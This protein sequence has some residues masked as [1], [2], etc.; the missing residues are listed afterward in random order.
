MN[1]MKNLLLTVLC[2][3]LSV[4][5]AVH[6]VEDGSVFN[7]LTT[8]IVTPHYAWG[9]ELRQGSIRALFVVA[10]NPTP[11]FKYGMQ[12]GARQVVE[13]AQRGDLD[14]D[15]VTAD[16][17]MATRKDDPQLA[18]FLDESFDSYRYSGTQRDDKEKDLLAKL[19]KPHDLYVLA[20]VSFRALPPEA[21]KII[22]RRVLD[23]AGLVLIGEI[24]TGLPKMFRKPSLDLAAEILRLDVNAPKLAVLEQA[25]RGKGDLWAGYQGPPLRAYE[26]GRGR[27]YQVTLP[28]EPPLVRST[29]YYPPWRQ[30]FKDFT[31]EEQAEWNYKNQAPIPI[32]WGRY[33]TMNGTF[34]RLFQYAA[35]RRPK[36]ALTCPELAAAPEF[37]AC[38]R[39][40][41]VELDNPRRLSGTIEYRVRSDENKL[42]A[43]GSARFKADRAALDLPAL[44]S[45]RYFLDLI[46]RVG[47]G[48]DDI[49]VCAFSVKADCAVTIR[50]G[51][52]RIR[53]GVPP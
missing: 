44:K 36:V 45:G 23:G 1:S 18:I 37:P 51:D 21:A 14:F 29:H 3:S 10:I 15:A 49:G 47:G 35:G 13:W 6:A 2:L 17:D 5:S 25:M 27:V 33:E 8:D 26:L 22:L 12:L 34:L 38:M 30:Y 48:V 20:W 40:V 43:S 11:A 50:R 41:T 46:S 19:E 53:D 52:D 24:G 31:P 32:W 4:L 42:M 16:L 7:D 9:Q 39:T 28:T